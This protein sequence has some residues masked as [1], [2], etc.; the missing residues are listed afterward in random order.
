MKK[1]I[2]IL[3]CLLAVFA[4]VACKE[5]PEN[6]S[7]GGDAIPP[8]TEVNGGTLTVNAAEGAAFPQDDR[9]QFLI[10]QPLKEDDEIEFLVKCSESFTSIV[11]R[12][13]NSSSEYAK[14]GTYD[15]DSLPEDGYGWFKVETDVTEDTEYFGITLYLE[16][17]AVQDETLF[18]SIKNLKINGKVVDFSEYDEE[19]CLATLQTPDALSA[20]ITK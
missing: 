4:I 16:A 7:G 18:I 8:A 9:F 11:P 5:E 6:T 2:V 1:V 13:G 14:F 15:F 3:L 19:T 17:E 20:V 10:A 12:S